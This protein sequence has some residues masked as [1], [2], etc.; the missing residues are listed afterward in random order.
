MKRT[1]FILSLALTAMSLTAQTN[2]SLSGEGA[3]LKEGEKLYLYAGERTPSDSAF[4]K[5]GK[6]SFALKG[7]EPCECSL[8]RADDEQHANMLLYLDNCPTYV[9]IGAGT[10]KNFNNTFMEAEVTGNPTHLKVQEV[11]DMIFKN[12]YPGKNPMDSP[13]FTAKLKEACGRADMAA[14]YIL[15]KYASVAS[16]F[17]IISDVKDC[18]DRMPEAVKA[19]VPGKDLGEQ[20]EK[21]LNVS[22]GYEAKDFTLNTPDG[23]AIRLSEYVKGK[24]IVLIDFW[25]SWCGPCRWAIPKVEQLYKRYDRSRLTV[26]SVSFDQK[27]AD[28]EKAMKEEAMPW[29][30]LWAGSR[31]QMTAA[32]QAYHISGI[33]R[34]MLIAPDGA[35][36]FSGNNADALRLAVEKYLGK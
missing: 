8:L 15:C 20:I 6:F 23:K 2:M 13:E 1:L 35:I 10:Y 34:L 11:N 19:S 27:Q 24:K 7:I 32:Q 22:V 36:V 4:V 26:V 12:T 28:W 25:A 30:Q 17:G 29:M 16:H 18:Y 3:T 5:G 14:A 9:K 33:P 21:Y 31:E